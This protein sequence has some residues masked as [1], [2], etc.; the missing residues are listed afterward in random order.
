MAQFA[1]DDDVDID[2]F[3]FSCLSSLLHLYL[4]L[5]FQESCRWRKDQTPQFNWF[6]ERMD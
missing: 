6:N 1:S 4:I 3:C 5:T 2:I